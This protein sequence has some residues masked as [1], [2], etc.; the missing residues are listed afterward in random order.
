MLINQEDLLHAH[1]CLFFCPLFLKMHWMQWNEWMNC[2][3]SLQCS[4]LKLHAINWQKRKKILKNKFSRY[5]LYT[6]KKWAN[7]VNK[8][9]SRL[10]TRLILCL[11]C[12]TLFSVHRKKGYCLFAT[13][14]PLALCGLT[15]SFTKWHF[16]ISVP[17]LP[18]RGWKLTSGWCWET[19][20]PAQL[21]YV[22]GIHRQRLADLLG[23]DPHL[24]V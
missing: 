1:N 17:C 24:A 10:K 3:F 15:T 21:E 18:H 16:P 6:A 4:I 5:I 22:R 13:E 12:T 20:L 8:K 23:Q 7:S 9:R 2:L 19:S 14:P 11:S